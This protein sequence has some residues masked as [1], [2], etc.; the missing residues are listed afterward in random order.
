MFLKEV[1]VNVDHQQERQF[2][3]INELLMRDDRWGELRVGRFSLIF[4]Q[5]DQHFLR[6]S[7]LSV[8]V[9]SSSSPSF[10]SIE[11]SWIE[12][13]GR[14]GREGGREGGEWGPDPPPAS[15]ITRQPPHSVKI[16]NLPAVVSLCFSL[17]LCQNS[18]QLLYFPHKLKSNRD[19]GKSYDESRPV[20]QSD[21]LLLQHSLLI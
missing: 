5:T 12:Y 3:I 17:D 13:T 15:A 19:E 10:T 9:F 7:R 21:R 8:F 18:A 2:Q 1:P 4:S 14:R 6:L 16:K 20:W 11:T